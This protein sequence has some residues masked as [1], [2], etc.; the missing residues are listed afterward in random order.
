MRKRIILNLENLRKLIKEEIVSYWL[1]EKKSASEKVNNINNLID[2]KKLMQKYADDKVRV[3]S[4]V[5]GM[6][7]VDTYDSPSKIPYTAV[8][9][10][11]MSARGYWKKGKLYSFPQQI[12]IKYQ[13]TDGGDR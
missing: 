1:L 10:P 13:N 6:A 5:F 4:I 8:G 12:L 9:D 7:Y 11:P 2:L 3:V